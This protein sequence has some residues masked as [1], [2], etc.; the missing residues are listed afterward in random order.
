MQHVLIVEDDTVFSNVLARSLTR[1]GFAVE[2]A[3][4]LTEARRKLLLLLPDAV[5]LDLCPASAT[6]RQVEAN[7][8]GGF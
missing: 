4:G 3:G 5:L 8:R 7:L 1:H 2:R 6:M